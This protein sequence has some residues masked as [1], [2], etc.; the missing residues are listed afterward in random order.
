MSTTTPTPKK[1]PSSGS[2][3]G[4][5]P[6]TTRKAPASSASTSKDA[7]P[8]NRSPSRMAASNSASATGTNTSSASINR[9]RSVRNGAGTPVSARAAARKP[10]NDASAT[11]SSDEDAKAELQA[12]LSELQQ[13]LQDS[14]TALSTSQRQADVLQVKLDEALKEQSILD[15]NV[16]E[17]TERLEELE[18]E[19]RELLRSK[20]EAEQI[21]ESERAATLRE[22]EEAVTREEEMQRSLMRMKE[23]L[24]Q[25]RA[26]SLGAADGEEGSW[27]SRRASRPLSISRNSS[28][29]SGA[30][31]PNPEM[32]GGQFA[33]SG[34][35]GVQRSDSR[36]SSR[37]VMQKDKMI[38]SLRL[39]LAEAQIKLVELE[40][41]GGSNL[42]QLERQMYDIKMQNARLMEENESF[43]LLLRDKTLNG[44]FAASDLLCAPSTNGD[45]S[46]PPSRNPADGLRQSGT[47]LAD[48]LGSA[49]QDDASTL[50]GDIGPDS[51]TTVTDSKERRLQGEV[52]SLKDQNKALTLYINNIISRLLQHE[53]FEQIL[54]KTPDLMAGPGAIS[55]KYAEVPPADSAPKP[56][57]SAGMDMEKDLPPPPPP[58]K[59]EPTKSPPP[60]EEP[61]SLL[62]RAGSVLRGRG[63][64]PPRPQSTMLNPDAAAEVNPTVH[65]NPDTAPRIPLGRSTST[66]GGG[67]HK[68]S[69]SDWPAAS[70]VTNMYK[71]PPSSG[72]A[73]P[74]SPGLGSPTAAARGSFFPPLG[75]GIRTASGNVV[76]SIDEVEGGDLGA[77]GLEN[78][79]PKPAASANSDAAAMPPPSTS[80]SDSTQRN[81]DPPSSNTFAEPSSLAAL[82]GENPS[83]PSSPPRSTA[84]SSSIAERDSRSGPAIMMGSK[85]RPLRLVQE[86]KE[87]KRPAS[88][89]AG[90]RGSWFGWMNKGAVSS[91]LQGVGRSVSG[92]SGAEPGQ[93]QEG[94]GGGQQ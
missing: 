61:Q 74:T 72:L 86:A 21:F 31:S 43:Q 32:S 80:R 57:S 13:R 53:Q 42:Q 88:G 78:Q 23:S 94:K 87:E 70:V 28:F 6:S 65:E 10:A 71:G 59:D 18:N 36:S 56:T 14:E 73:G 67:G 90:Q 25:Q 40:N 22:R 51:A 38:E 39:D 93:G 75:A 58:H 30:A 83:N 26:G 79:I 27:E 29:R 85:P 55:R 91:G 64:K 77:A 89:G 37:L 76:P 45:G 12:Q 35:A 9:T 69:N 60:G 49:N 34:G 20:R 46:R 63:T 17:N 48:E 33:P 1:T 54:D 4:S 19:K 84:S 24:A 7:P 15:E 66:R 92:G 16:H 81:S 82:T 11:S 50:D 8:L 52:N 3:T 44:D 47:S 2:G 41:K 62:Q 5:A 68:R